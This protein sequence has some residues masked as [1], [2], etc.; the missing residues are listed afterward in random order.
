MGTLIFHILVFLFFIISY[1]FDEKKTIKEEAILLDF[2]IIK[3]SITIPEIEKKKSENADKGNTKMNDRGSNKAVN[4]AAKSDNF[5]DAAYKNDIEEA[6]NL[7]ADVNK[8][9]TKKVVKAKQ[10]EMP[11][12]ITE[13]Q[14]PDSIKNTIYSGKSNIHYNLE[15]R[16]HIRLP[17]PVYLAKGGGN[18]K[19]DIQVNRQGKVI[20]ALVGSSTN[21]N[22]PMLPTYAVQAAERTLFNSDSKAP[23]VQQGTIIYQFVP[24]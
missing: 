21:I 23:E 16:Y 22:V 9:L 20:K 3:E 19:V 10:Y 1:S 2:K 5:F 13:G 7:V 24:Q 12:S 6:K 18:I 17:I 11:E 4:D 15:N 14:K 8:Q